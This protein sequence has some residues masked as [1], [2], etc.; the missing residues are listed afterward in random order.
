MES[1]NAVLIIKLSIH[2]HVSHFGPHDSVLFIEVSL[3]RGV[4]I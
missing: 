1:L 3:F 4:C 2:V